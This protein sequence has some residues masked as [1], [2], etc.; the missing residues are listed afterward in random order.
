M[1]EKKNLDRLF[2]EKFKDFEAHPSDQ[3]W[4][5][6]VAAKAKKKED[7][8]V[9]I[10]WWRLGG[11]A[12]LLLLLVTTGVVVWNSSSNEIT[13]DPAL[14]ETNQTD[15]DKEEKTSSGIADTNTDNS[16]EKTE[17]LQQPEM[18]SEV[19]VDANKS[20]EGNNATTLSLIHI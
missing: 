1:K 15:A 5:N 18:S 6:I 12:A 13:S 16:T 19:I 7:R 2:Q 4:K 20:Q 10:I 8:K 14:V 11:V 9:A 17:N 3:V